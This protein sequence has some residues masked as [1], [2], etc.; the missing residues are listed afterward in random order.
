MVAKADIA[1][2]GSSP[3]IMTGPP[4]GPL[5]PLATRS[6]GTEQ[7]DRHTTQHPTTHSGAG[8]CCCCL[9]ACLRLCAEARG[10]LCFGVPTWQSS[11]HFM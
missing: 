5:S 2:G 4:P 1:P 8:C 7:T 10:V 6:N 11:A 3:V 9:R